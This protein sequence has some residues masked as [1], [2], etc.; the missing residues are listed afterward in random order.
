[1]T[2]KHCLKCNWYL[3]FERYCPMWAFETDTDGTELPDKPCRH[4]H[5]RLDTEDGNYIIKGDF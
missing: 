5:L 4:Y 1:M 2:P 3:R